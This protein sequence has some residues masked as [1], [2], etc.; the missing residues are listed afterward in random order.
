MN[1]PKTRVDTVRLQNI[2]YGHKQSAA[3]RAAIELDLFTA[4]S[5]GAASFKEIARKLE[6]NELNAERLIVAC[7]GMGLLEKE[8]GGYK[9]AADAERF[10]V[11][12]KPTYVGP[13]LLFATQDFESWKNLKQYLTTRDPPRVLGIYES[14]TDETAREY[15]EATYSVGLGAG[16]LFARDVDMSHRKL[17]LDLGGGSGAYCIAALNRYPHL[18]AIV[19]D[20]EPVTKMTREF[21]AQWGLEDKISTLSGNFTSDP[22]P[23]G[24]DVIIQASN[25]PQYNEETLIKIMKKGFN[26]LVPGGEYHVVGETVSDGKDGALGPAL[27]GLHE[28]LFGSL[29]RAHSEREVKSYLKTA[30]YVN[31]EVNAFI[32]GSLTRIAGYKPV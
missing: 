10:L 30:G 27:W 20:F 17:V 32:P 9:N 12:G 6:I 8:E 3:L 21:V 26:A 4:V 25:L 1:A 29:G 22:F 14:L 28:A 19:M 7:A 5:K 18:K 23:K 24:P 16:F 2:S 11:K 15:H 31:I 13:W